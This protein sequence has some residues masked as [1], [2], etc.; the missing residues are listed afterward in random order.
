MPNYLTEEEIAELMAVP[1]AHIPE[2]IK[3]LDAIIKESKAGLKQ[4]ASYNKKANKSLKKGRAG[5]QEQN[6]LYEALE[7]LEQSE[8]QLNEVLRKTQEVKKFLRARLKGK[9][10][11]YGG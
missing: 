8:V 7:E 10:G 3:E 2:I 5:T 4:A 9:V 6:G 11:G 1:E